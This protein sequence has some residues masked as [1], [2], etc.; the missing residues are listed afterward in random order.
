MA[1]AKSGQKLKGRFSLLRT[2][3]ENQW[4]LIKGNDEFESKDDLT[5]TRPESVITGRT[6]QDLEDSKGDNNTTKS[7][8]ENKT[9]IREAKRKD[10][11]TNNI[12]NDDNNN[13]YKIKD[14]SAILSKRS[15]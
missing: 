12:I 14:K 2:S 11:E 8:N 1:F 15:I 10:N 6:N 5:V 13:D 4:L 3:R 7:N 9:V